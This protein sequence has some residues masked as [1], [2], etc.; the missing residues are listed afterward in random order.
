MSD[1]TSKATDFRSNVRQDFFISFFFFLGPDQLAPWEEEEGG[2]G[3]HVGW[4]DLSDC[5]MRT[6]LCTS[7]CTRPCLAPR[8]VPIKEADS[9]P[10]PNVTQPWPFHR[11]FRR[12]ASVAEQ[13]VDGRNSR[14][15]TSSARRTH[16][17]GFMTLVFS[18]CS[19]ESYLSGVHLTS[20]LYHY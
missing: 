14:H 17:D 8:D 15:G 10:W 20:I 9:Q 6:A 5:T 13:E 7:L 2:G 11:Q 18:V 12:L 19:C 4:P 3:Y 16:S 1:N